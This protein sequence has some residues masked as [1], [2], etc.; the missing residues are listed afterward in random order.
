VLVDFTTTM[1]RLPF[2]SA[3]GHARLLVDAIVA[4]VL[5]SNPEVM[6][7]SNPSVGAKSLSHEWRNGAAPGELSGSRIPPES[8]DKSLGIA[9]QCSSNPTAKSYEVG[10]SLKSAETYFHNCRLIC[11]ANVK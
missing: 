2:E 11:S 7:S 5:F 1:P 4:A 6:R 8:P 3:A 10:S 9:Q